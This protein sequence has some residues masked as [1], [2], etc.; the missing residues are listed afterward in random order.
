MEKR[1]HG[2]IDARRRIIVTCSH[3]WL[4]C[5]SRLSCVGRACMDRGIMGKGVCSAFW[6]GN[7]FFL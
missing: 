4:V 5:A 2:V 3:N 6:D 1:T 7:C